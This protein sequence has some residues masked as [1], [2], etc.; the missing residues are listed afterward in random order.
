[1][2]K[3]LH[4]FINFIKRDKR[5]LLHTVLFLITAY[6][7][8]SMLVVMMSTTSLDTGVTLRLQKF[9]T[10]ALDTFMNIISWFASIPGGLITMGGAAVAFLLAGKRREALF[11]IAP[12]LAVPIVSIVKRL[13]NRARPT[14]DLVRVVGDFH[15]ESFPSGH[16]VFYTVLFGFLA[17]LMYRHQDLPKVVRVPVSLVSIFLILSVPFSRMYLGAHWF[18]DVVAG[19]CLGCLLLIGLAA[20]YDAGKK[21]RVVV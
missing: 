21:K 20:W 18:T 4:S 11:V 16:V 6:V 17:Y 5:W 7:V 3:A 8:M 12:I 13:F 1:M 14:A 9:H 2:A 19:F 15:N 10:P